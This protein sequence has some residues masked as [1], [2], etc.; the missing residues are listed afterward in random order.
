[1][2]IEAQRIYWT[3]QR[4]GS[5]EPFTGGSVA[6]CEIAGCCAQPEVLWTGDGQPSAITTDSDFVYWVNEKSSVVWKVAKP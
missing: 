2:T 1:M 4:V 6:T 5:A 3:N